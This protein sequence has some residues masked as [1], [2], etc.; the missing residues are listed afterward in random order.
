M[1]RYR[2]DKWKKTPLPYQAAAAKKFP[3][4]LVRRLRETHRHTEWAREV[5][6]ES[7]RG[8][9]FLGWRVHRATGS[10]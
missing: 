2:K 3:L 6:R 5:L 1:K 10:I 4:V 7:G 9:K 8:A